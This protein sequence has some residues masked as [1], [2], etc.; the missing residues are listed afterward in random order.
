MLGHTPA[1]S[2]PSSST[3]ATST[4]ATATTTGA[5]GTAMDLSGSNNNNIQQ[6]HVPTTPLPQHHQN[7]RHHP[8]SSSGL[9][10]NSLTPFQQ[11]Q[12]HQRR[13]GSENLQDED[14]DEDDNVKH[15]RRH[16]ISNSGNSDPFSLQMPS[17]ASRTD[18]GGEHSRNSSRLM[19][20]PPPAL[21]IMPP[22]PS[23]FASAKKP[24]PT[25]NTS[26]TTTTSNAQY[27]D[28]ENLFLAPSPFSSASANTSIFSRPEGSSASHRPLS[29][30]P[31]LLRPN[32]RQSTSYPSEDRTLRESPFFPSPHQNAANGSFHHHV[33]FTST[34][35]LQSP[36]HPSQQQ[37]QPPPHPFPSL[38]PTHSPHPSSSLST[39]SAPKNLAPHHIFTT[40]KMTKL[41]KPVASAFHSTGLLSKRGG[42][43]RSNSVSNHEMM[44]AGT[45]GGN[46]SGGFGSAGPNLGMFGHGGMGMNA[47]GAGG[48]VGGAGGNSVE[49]PETPC[50]KNPGDKFASYT[51]DWNPRGFEKSVGIVGGVPTPSRFEDGGLPASSFQQNP[52]PMR[53]NIPPDGGFRHAN[54]TAPMQRVSGMPSQE[55]QQQQQ[56]LQQMQ[57]QQAMVPPSPV[58]FD[59]F[60]PVL[61]AV[62]APVKK[63]PDGFGFGA[64]GGLGDRKRGFELDWM[65]TGEIAGGGGNGGLTGGSGSSEGL[66]G[67]PLGG[68]ARTVSSPGQVEF[69]GRFMMGRLGDGGTPLASPLKGAGLGRKKMLVLGDD[70]DVV[71]GGTG[72]SE[73]E[74]K[75]PLLVRLFGAKEEEEE[76]DGMGGSGGS[77]FLGGGS[78]GGGAKV[79]DAME[80]D[81]DDPFQGGSSPFSLL[82]AVGG[83]HA[84]MMASTG[85]HGT[86][87]GGAG[88]AG[89]NAAG[90]GNGS[91]GGPNSSFSISLSSSTA[92]SLS[93]SSTP[94]PTLPQGPAQQ[95]PLHS[96]AMDGPG[97][98]VF[99]GDDMEVDGDVKM[100][101]GEWVGIGGDG[102]RGGEDVQQTEKHP[103]PLSLYI[104]P[105]AYFGAQG[106]LLGAGGGDV[107]PEA[108][109]PVTFGP[110]PGFT[111]GAIRRS[112]VGERT[113]GVSG[114]G[115]GGGGGEGRGGSGGAGSV[116]GGAVG[117][118]IPR[119]ASRIGT[120]IPGIVGG[121]GGSGLY[122]TPWARFLTREYFREGRHR[123]ESLAA[124]A[125]LADRSM[126]P[127]P[128]PSGPNAF[129]PGTSASGG[130]TGG[131]SG[132]TSY[133]DYFE[134]NFRLVK[135]LGHGSFAEAFKVQSKLD[136]RMY[137]IK[138]SR[139]V[140]TGRKDRLA[141]LEEVEI[142]WEVKD[143]PR[144]VQ[145]LNA[146]EQFGHIYVQMELCERGTLQA[147]LEERGGEVMADEVLIWSVLAVVCQGLEYIHGLDIVHL[148]LKPGNLFITEDGGLKIGDFGL[149]TRC[150]VSDGFERE[151]DRTYIAPEILVSQYGKPCDI[152]SLGLIVLEMMA[153]IIL[154]ENGPPWH[155]LREHDFSESGFGTCQ[156]PLI[157][158]VRAMLNPSPG[159][160]PGAGDVL[161]H[162]FVKA[163]GYEGEGFAVI[164]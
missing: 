50:K 9:L 23:P 17:S 63:R 80:D 62:T 28:V 21:K 82:K 74:G 73:G 5:G 25:F 100:G 52:T 26:T 153:N 18:L 4:S 133:A 10:S 58:K 164:P 117:V 22:P 114:T 44:G 132:G 110:P 103:T 151:G 41:V 34:T 97:K 94:S 140:I 87:G 157:D 66:V 29:P 76:G 59:G 40:P 129:R 55:Q 130:T 13:K 27:P 136:G 64:P 48:G 54:F 1:P 144:I 24:S 71:V 105:S 37:Q 83:G 125:R 38:T 72:E 155:K 113:A 51:G 15:K 108:I 45:V 39:A 106:G 49:T 120:G 30:S 126:I 7:K 53:M 119:P 77:K 92:S 112:L 123:V 135:K 161:G 98:D 42:R 86:V 128:V 159:M 57:W 91:N 124:G 16:G 79:R 121:L 6:Q 46:A 156:P 61:A 163:L 3:T 131:S 78:A 142:L 75:K 47:G 67:S 20:P 102:R 90:V 95:N 138:R 137:A 12:L 115:A 154:P 146:W 134:T 11:Q 141:K 99:G 88:G 109:T 148:D 89:G 2:T 162:P 8:P 65:E 101:N 127:L 96:G 81:E 93:H 111:D 19:P 160:R 68:R 139:H 32:S 104:T 116:G 152:F 31:F 107:S 150:P 145:V 85:S 60:K 35:P 147:Y 143:G 118:G 36:R 70:E 14:S 43:V 33:S 158:V 122:V 56:H 69:A 149:A 84:P